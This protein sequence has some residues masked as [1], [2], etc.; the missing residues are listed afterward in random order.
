VS[1][2][3]NLR[4]PLRKQAVALKA[5]WL[6]AFQRIS[7]TMKQANKHVSTD[8]LLFNDTSSTA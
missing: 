7:C 2:V 4:V 8:R 1:T 3:L 6:S 5:E